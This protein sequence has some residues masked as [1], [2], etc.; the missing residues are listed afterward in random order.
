V[1]LAHSSGQLE[2]A[3]KHSAMV[4]LHIEK[5]HE[6]RVQENAQSLQQQGPGR[7]DRFAKIAERQSAKGNLHLAADA[8][9]AAATRYGQAGDHVKANEHRSKAQALD[10]AR[11]EAATERAESFSGHA[12]AT[13]VDANHALAMHAH[14][15][16]AR[17]HEEL[18]NKAQARLHQIRAK[19][20]KGLAKQ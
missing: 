11:G 3:A 4:R 1:G 20:H 18:E 16:A 5:A 6:A 12:N 14:L 13:G 8:H 19:R 9:G 2:R 15:E 10:V 17:V 7:A